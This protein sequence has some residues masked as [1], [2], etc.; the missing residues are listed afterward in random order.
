VPSARGSATSEVRPASGWRAVRSTSEVG[1]KPNRRNV[2]RM[3]VRK[4]GVYSKGREGTVRIILFLERAGETR[5]LGKRGA[6]GTLCNLAGAGR[7]ADC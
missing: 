4:D 5:T 3:S 2:T 6:D 1:L 7:H